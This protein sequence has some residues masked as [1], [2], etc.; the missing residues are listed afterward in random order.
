MYLSGIVNQVKLQQNITEKFFLT[1]WCYIMDTGGTP[2]RLWIFRKFVVINCICLHLFAYR[3]TSSN[4]VNQS[5]TFQLKMFVEDEFV[6]EHSRANIPAQT[7][8]DSLS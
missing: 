1:W 2:I 8:C 3:P 4:R 7:H 5:Q 6:E